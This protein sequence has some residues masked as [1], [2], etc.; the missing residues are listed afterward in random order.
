MF[1]LILHSNSAA[2]L[3]VA[4]ADFAQNEAAN[5]LIYGLALRLVSDPERFQQPPFTSV[6]FLATVQQEDDRLV[7]A[8]LMTPPYRLVIYAPPAPP[9]A[10]LD[11]VIA[12]L[13][14]NGWR[15]SGVIGETSI[16]DLF[17][18]RWQAAIGN[19]YHVETQMRIYE[20]RAVQWPVL[21][22]GRL[23]PA[24]SEDEALVYKWY[25]DFTRETKPRDPLPS[26]E[27]VRRS[28]AQGHIYLWNDGGPVSLAARGRRLPH[29]YS[30]GPV[31]TPPALRGF[32]YA[33]A[34][35]AALSQTILDTGAHFCTLFTDLANPTSNAIYQRIGY[36]PVCDF[37]EYKFG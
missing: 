29:G 19:L 27:G 7:C 33:S 9:P 15:A 35:T 24:A 30:V 37:T 22:P 23:R 4:E 8:A 6:P 16:S 36:R 5:N 28:L 14:S 1:S 13:Q 32:G 26:L 17:A 25:C 21:P 3:Q 18:E 31:Y 2:F 10:A 34:C 12:S 20:L 11:M